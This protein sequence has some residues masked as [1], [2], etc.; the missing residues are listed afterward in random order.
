[1]K[2]LLMILFVHVPEH[3]STVQALVFQKADSTI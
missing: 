2:G 3:N 1:M